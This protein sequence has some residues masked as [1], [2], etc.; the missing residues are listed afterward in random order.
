MQGVPLAMLDMSNPNYGFVR[1]LSDAFSRTSS[2]YMFPA[3]LAA[4]ISVAISLVAPAA[5]E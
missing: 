2:I 1:F 3:F 5:C 4:L